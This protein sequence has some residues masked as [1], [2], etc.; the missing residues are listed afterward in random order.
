M[1]EFP[2]ME[3][4]SKH[5]IGVIAQDVE[6]VLPELIS[7]DD[8][9]YK[10]VAYDKLSAVLIEAIKEQ[11]KYIETLENKN[12]QLEERLSKLEEAILK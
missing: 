11:Q 1:D 5:Q 6:K 3:L 9:G 7:E 4:S 12:K 10:A 8:K 2:E